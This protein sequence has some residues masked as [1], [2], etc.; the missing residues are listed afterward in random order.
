MLR[1]G[2]FG[3]FLTLTQPTFVSRF[4]KCGFL[5]RAIT[6]EGGSRV[7]F[8]FRLYSWGDFSL[9]FA[10]IFMFPLCGIAGK[11]DPILGIIERE[12]RCE[13]YHSGH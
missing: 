3:R 8:I 12:K 9:D 6:V 13:S 2:I 11:G 4:L 7:A 5:Y 1:A 10:L